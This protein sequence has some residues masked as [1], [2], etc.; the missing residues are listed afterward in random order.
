M[1]SIKFCHSG[2]VDTRHCTC[3][4]QVMGV[5]LG[6]SQ[7]AVQRQEK[8]GFSLCRMIGWQWCLSPDTGS[9]HFV[10]NSDGT[11]NHGIAASSSQMRHYLTDDQ[12]QAR[13]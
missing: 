7:H 6:K 3:H 5:K 4:G 8:E 1:L 13:G 11:L 2:P 9:L 10:L 12:G